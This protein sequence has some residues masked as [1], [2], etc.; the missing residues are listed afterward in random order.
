[1]TMSQHAGSVD[2]RLGI[3]PDD[4]ASIEQGVPVVEGT[5]PARQLVSLAADA[6]KHPWV[7]FDPGLE[8]TADCESAITFVDGEAGILLHRG[9]PIEELIDRPFLDVA[10]LLIRGELPGRQA[11]GEWAAD[12]SAADLPEAV[13]ELAD[14]VPTTAHPM[15]ALLATWALTGAY[16]DDSHELVD[17]DRELPKILGRFGHVA[18]LVVSGRRDGSAGGPSDASGYGARILTSINADLDRDPRLID[19]IN[20]L[21]VLHADHEQNCSTH[22]VR[23]VASSKMGPYAAISAGIAALAGP[24]HG[25]AN[26]AAVRMLHEIG[27]PSSVPDF[28]SKVKLGERRLMGFGHR[29]YKTYDPRARL[30]R[31]VSKQVFEAVGQSRLIETAEALERAALEDDYFKERR[32]FPNVDFYSGLVYEAVG[33]PSSASTVIFA[34]ARVAG[35]LAQWQEMSRDPKGRIIRPRQIYRGSPRRPVMP[36]GDRDTAKTGKCVSPR[37]DNAGACDN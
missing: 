24:L 33:V 1:M 32:L 37:V 4:K 17:A 29:V 12:V 21:L 28:I 31:E 7:I 13:K 20:S 35:W 5:I 36:P 9:Y 25:G 8:N 6:G 14:N 11:S 26:E 23:A 30:V 18:G 34:A 27:D 19:A 22:V 2:P 3:L 16:F 15:S 10:Y